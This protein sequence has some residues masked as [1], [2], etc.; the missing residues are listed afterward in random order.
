L[1]CW[2]R[3]MQPSLRWVSSMPGSCAHLPLRIRWEME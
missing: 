1:R 2:S 3:V